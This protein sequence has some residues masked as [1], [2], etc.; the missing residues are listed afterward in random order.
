[1]RYRK[2]DKARI[3]VTNDLP[4]KNTTTVHWHGVRVSNAMDGVLQVTQSPIAVGDTFTYEFP[5]PDSG[6]YWYHPH[7]MSYEQVARGM[8]G[9]FI[10]EEDK[11][12]EVDRELLWVLSDFKLE[13]GG[14]QLQDFGR[15]QDLGGGGHLGNVFALNGRQAGRENRLTVRSGERLRLRLV[16]TATAR[17]FLL[18]FLGQ[19]PMVI[20]YDGCSTATSWNTPPAA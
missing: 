5:M 6:T 8:Y 13:P 11:P 17:I 3:V 9:A 4:G 12:L 1:L 19:K 14:R 10:V 2:G 16:N 20:S 7:Q 15:M 18:D